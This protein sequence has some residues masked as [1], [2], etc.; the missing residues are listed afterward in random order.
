MGGTW[1]AVEECHSCRNGAQWTSLVLFTS[2][3]RDFPP[4]SSLT[5]VSATEGAETLCQSH[6]ESMEATL[7][8]S[9]GETRTQPY[10][11]EPVGAAVIGEAE[12]WR[13]ICGG[14]AERVVKV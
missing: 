12:A 13:G 1:K 8:E 2:S 9:Y 7:T 14:V 11:A 3:S 6:V 10:T 5:F 4:P